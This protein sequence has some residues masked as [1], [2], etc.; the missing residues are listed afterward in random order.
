M[1]SKESDALKVLIRL[2][3]SHTDS[4]DTKLSLDTTSRVVNKVWTVKTLTIL[5]G[6]IQG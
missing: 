6:Y 5:E 2:N 1:Q 3:F 4:E